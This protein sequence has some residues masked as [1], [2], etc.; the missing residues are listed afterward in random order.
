MKPRL[1][2]ATLL[3]ALSLSMAA[4]AQ[5]VTF[6]DVTKPQNVPVIAH[7][8][9]IAYFDELEP[10]SDSGPYVLQPTTGAIAAQALSPGWPQ[11]SI[12]LRGLN[13]FVLTSAH[14]GPSLFAGFPPVQGVLVK[15]LRNGVAVAQSVFALDI[16]D[17]LNPQPQYQWFTPAGSDGFDQPIDTLQFFADG[18]SLNSFNFYLDGLNVAPVPEPE[19]WALLGLG[20]VGLM[21]RRTRGHQATRA[22]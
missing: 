19:T 2:L 8:F 7:G 17:P 16:G 1:Q 5:L 6:D 20:L 13:P 21:A 14:L 10:S 9:E 3:A 22:A 18:G 11:K 4:H 15:G 12:E